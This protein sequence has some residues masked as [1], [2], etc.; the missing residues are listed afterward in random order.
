MEADL[1]WLREDVNRLRNDNA[2]YRRECMALRSDPHY[3]EV[4]ARKELGMKRSGEITNIQPAS[5]TKS[6]NRFSLNVSS[7]PSNAS[8]KILPRIKRLLDHKP[9]IRSILWVLGW[10]MTGSAFVFE[11]PAGGVRKRRIKR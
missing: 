2:L 7:P 8:S 1:T 4:V 3:I 9:I 6:Q 10:A 5:P 11:I